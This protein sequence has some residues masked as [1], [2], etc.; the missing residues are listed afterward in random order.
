MEATRAVT[1]AGDEE[2]LE[3]ERGSSEVVRRDAETSDRDVD[4]VGVLNDAVVLKEVEVRV[5]ERGTGVTEAFDL[6][7]V[8]VELLGLDVDGGGVAKDFVVEE[9]LKVTE[10]LVRKREVRLD[11]LVDD[12]LDVGVGSVDERCRMRV[13]RLLLVLPVESVGGGDRT[14]RVLVLLERAERVLGVDAGAGRVEGRL[15]VCACSALDRAKG[16]G[17]RTRRG[18]AARRH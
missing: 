9:V 12:V 13:P 1:D 6:R 5:A 8:A 17:L 4:V 15:G 11:E 7:P 16:D 2:L 14:V 18:R 3:V 10:R